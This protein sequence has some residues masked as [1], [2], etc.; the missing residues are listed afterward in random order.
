MIHSE[1]AI[2]KKLTRLASSTSDIIYCDAENH[3][4]KTVCEI[5]QQPQTEEY[6]YDDVVD[7]IKRLASY[8]YLTLL[9]H[10]TD[11]YLSVTY[12]GLHLSEYTFD[13]FR[14]AFFCKFLY[15]LISGVI[16]GVASTLIVQCLLG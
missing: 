9:D 15:G 4:F 13:R 1:R 7:I 5:S 14:H 6:P 16:V 8:E 2:L 12:V 11:I 10:P 3:C